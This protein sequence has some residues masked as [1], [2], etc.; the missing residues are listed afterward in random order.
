MNKI[1]NDLFNNPKNLTQPYEPKSKI[2]IEFA[3]KI[4]Y[5]GTYIKFKGEKKLNEI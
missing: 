1:I 3:K 4:K 2:I 5:T